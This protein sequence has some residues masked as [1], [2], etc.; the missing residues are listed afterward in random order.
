MAM[1]KA[2]YTIDGEVVGEESGGVRTDY[3][4]D[5]LGSVVGTVNQSAQVV[6][7]YRY[8]PYGARLAKTGAGA[9]PSVQWVGTGGYRQTGKK[10]SE[11]YAR[12]RHYDTGAGTWTSRDPAA[13]G[14]SLARIT[15][16]RS[17]RFLFAFLRRYAARSD[18]SYC[19]AS[20][21]GL[22][23]PYGLR[24]AKPSD[25]HHIGPVPPSCKCQSG[26][27][28][29]N[30][31]PMD[32]A[33]SG[34]DMSTGHMWT[35]NCDVDCD[36]PCV[37]AHEGQHRHDDAI[38]CKRAALCTKHH[39]ASA[40]DAAYRQ[41]VNDTEK[42]SECRAFSSGVN[43][44]EKMLKAL[45]CWHC[46]PGDACCDKLKSVYEKDRR[47]RDEYCKGINPWGKPNKS[48]PF[49]SQGNII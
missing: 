29:C 25:S 38:C 48:C 11:S 21:G 30:G 26:V 34:C 41:W 18:Y 15:V 13:P 22:T 27:V 33:D 46:P 5:A 10:W 37:D 14:L 49:D 36:S 9:D 23:D 31:L 6:N 43:C 16:F 7:T 17:P 45:D 24:P 44:M 39:P 47:L 35:L 3:L 28:Y 20:P 40:C 32:D 4:R 19:S 2:Y 42:W 8:K 1:S 12:A